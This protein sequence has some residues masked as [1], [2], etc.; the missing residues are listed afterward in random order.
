MPNTWESD[1]VGAGAPPIRTDEGWLEIYHAADANGRYALGAM[2]SDLDRPEVIRSRSD[3]P[4]LEPVEP[5]EQAG[6]YANCVFSNGVLAEP[7]GRLT[8]YYGAADAIC[9]AALTTVEEMV[10]AAENRE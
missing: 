7:D 6:V 8:I 1:R 10:A 9:A 2:L 4:V 5:Y 3:R